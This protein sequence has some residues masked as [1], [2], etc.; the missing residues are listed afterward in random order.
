MD[1][2]QVRIVRWRGRA[3]HYHQKAADALSQGS[4]MAFQA[5]A[6]CA[7]SVADRMETGTLIWLVRPD[8]RVSSAGDRVDDVPPQQAT[9]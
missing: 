7:D 1:D 4:R 5:V 3:D 9:R 6:E 2:E 8:R